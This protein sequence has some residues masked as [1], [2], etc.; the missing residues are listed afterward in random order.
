MH[1]NAPV[2][3]S[4]LTIDE[5]LERGSWVLLLNFCA[6]GPQGTVSAQKRTWL[7]PTV[8]GRLDL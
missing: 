6:K 3:V 7:C 4:D 5:S 2:E 8:N 1:V